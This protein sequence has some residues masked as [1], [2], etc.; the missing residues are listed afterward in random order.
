MVYILVLVKYEN[1]Q[2]S[3][4]NVIIT[5]PIFISSRQNKDAQNINTV[6][7]IKQYSRSRTWAIYSNSLEI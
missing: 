2:P 4:N 5:V 6:I 1:T 3:I 7:T